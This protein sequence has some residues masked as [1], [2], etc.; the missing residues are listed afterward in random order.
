MAAASTPILDAGKLSGLTADEVRERI[1]AGQV[2]TTP[3]KIGDSYWRIIRRN[4]LTAVNALLFAIAGGLLL[5]ER[6]RDAFFTGGLVLLN[7]VVGTVQE[8]R[9]KR[10]VEHV[11]LLTRPRATVIRD[12]QR[13]DLDPAEIVLG[14]LIVI[15]AGDQIPADGELLTDRPFAV[16]ESNLTGELDLVRKRTGDEV[17]AGTTCIVGSGVCEAIRVGTESALQQVTA[18][19]RQY[20]LVQTPLQREVD[21]IL[22]AM[23]VLVTILAL[24]VFRTFHDLYEAKVPVADAVTTSAVLISLV[25]QGLVAMTV[26]A[27][28]LAIARLMPA[29]I[30]VQR[31]NAVESLSHIDVLCVDK[32]GTLTTQRLTVETATPF[33]IGEDDLAR[34]LGDFV[35][36]S[37]FRN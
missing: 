36:T 20:R 8:I 21:L 19:A 31:I 34:R 18:K 28:S 30:L 1:E 10:Q 22:R 26:I 35:A 11:A 37:C 17:L 23:V 12:G 6:P 15:E 29:G 14:D 27:Y 5:L 2:N 33:G 16:D 4:G 9:A 32:T 13:V 7:S 24:P 25:P 3:V